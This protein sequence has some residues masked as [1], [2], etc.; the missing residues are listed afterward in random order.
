MSQNRL[1]YLT[2]MSIESDLLR[3][4]NFSDIVKTF[5]LQKAR[6]AYISL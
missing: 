3:E 6:K 1:S 2:L 5:V 4:I